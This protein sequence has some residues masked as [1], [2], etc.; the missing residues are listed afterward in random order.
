MREKIRDLLN[1]PVSFKAMRNITFGAAAAVVAMM[2]GIGSCVERNFDRKLDE[3]DQ[4]FD[5]KLNSLTQKV[6]SE[7]A[8]L[9]DSIHGKLV[10]LRGRRDAYLRAR[11]FMEKERHAAITVKPSGREE[12]I[13]FYQKMYYPGLWQIDTVDKQPEKEITTLKYST[14]TEK[15]KGYLMLPR[16]FRNR[17]LDLPVR[18]DIPLQINR[19]RQVR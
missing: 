10:S 4:Y 17:K 11:K 7:L 15:G 16:E 13:S 5:R 19:P 14:E 18:I 6:D 1:R 2:I 9:T 8:A 12:L 3:L